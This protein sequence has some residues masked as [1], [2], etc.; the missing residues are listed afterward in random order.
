M[1]LEGTYT[2]EASREFVWDMLQDPEVISS[3]IPGS[4]QLEEIGEN[5]YLSVLVVKVGPVNGRFEGQVELTDLN[6]PES[7]TMIM[8]GK[9]P[10]GHMN[11]TGN[12]RLEEQDGT[13]I[14]HY[15]GD[16]KVG[17][18]IAAVGQRL[19]D[20][21]AKQLAKQSLNLLAKRIQERIAAGE[22]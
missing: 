6:A 12:V 11:G 19:L 1:K 5:K 10:A 2:F 13:T 15:T 17:G 18:K 8:S 22:S 20:V 9:G 4:E 14:M 7:Y 21:A 16:A 3:I